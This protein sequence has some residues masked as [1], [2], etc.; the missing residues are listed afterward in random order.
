MPQFVPIVPSETSRRPRPVE[1]S[2]T[3]RTA[4]DVLE[5]PTS[6]VDVASVALLDQKIGSLLARPSELEVPAIQICV[7][8]ITCIA[9]SFTPL[10]FVVPESLN[11][12]KPFDC[13]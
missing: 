3:L 13:Q 11:C 1:P 9:L 8:P 5:S 6:F 12:R 10:A 4:A 7:D 2:F